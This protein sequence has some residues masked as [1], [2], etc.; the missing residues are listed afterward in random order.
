MGERA[1]DSLTSASDPAVIVVTTAAEGVRAGCLVGYH[2]QSSMVPQHYSVWL[3][4]ANHTYRTGLRAAHFAAHFL[5]QDDLDLAELFATV[6]GEDRDKFADLEVGTADSGVPVIRQ[7]PHHMLLERTAVLDDGGDHVCV[8]ARVLRSRTTGPFA[9]LR[10]SDVAHL[11]P[12]R[13][14]EDRAVRP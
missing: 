10:I 9:P 8:A 6:S 2:A 7:L 14:A 12:G 13:A 1:F 11:R 5:T 4:K 3:S